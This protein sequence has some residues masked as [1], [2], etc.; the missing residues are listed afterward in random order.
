MNES[1]ESGS[2]DYLQEIEDLT[3]LVESGHDLVKGGSQ[4]DM[5]NLE[6][7]IADLCRRLAEV[8]PSDPEAVTAAIHHLVSRLGALSDAL[9]VQANQRN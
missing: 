3:K 7:P 1:P 5:T 4:V 8:P 9:Q 6:E 2:P